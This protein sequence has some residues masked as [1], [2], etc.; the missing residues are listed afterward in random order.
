MAGAPQPGEHTGPQQRGLAGSRGPEQHQQT[1]A[2]EGA[3]GAEPLDQ[4]ADLPI[5]AEVDGSVFLL[6]RRQAR[7]GGTGAIP[8]EAPLGRQRDLHQLLPE[9]LKASFTL[10]TQI[11]HLQV[12]SDGR[13]GIAFSSLDHL[14]DRLSEGTGLLELSEAPLGSSPVGALEN[15]HR[16]RLTDLAKE[17]LLPVR[18]RWNANVSIKVEKWRFETLLLQP[19]LHAAGGGIVAARMGKE[20]AGH[21][22]TLNGRK[23]ATSLGC[24]T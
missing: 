15:Q 8:G 17:G 22:Q 20:D 2:T 11:E 23:L 12:W 21:E 19:G 5:T 4:M 9:L 10:V 24:V 6:K 7:I 14:E 18:P 1:G 3:A 16:L 13:A